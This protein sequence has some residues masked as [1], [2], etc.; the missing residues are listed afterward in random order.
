V[1]PEDYA[2]LLDFTT[3]IDE[4]EGGVYILLKTGL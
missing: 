2:E 4:T 3:R 1:A